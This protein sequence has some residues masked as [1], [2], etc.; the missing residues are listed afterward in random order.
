MKALSY[1]FLLSVLPGLSAAG[2]IEDNMKTFADTE[3]RSK[4]FDPMIIAAIKGA[5]LENAAITPEEI[6]ALDSQWKQD[7]G[8]KS[9]LISG[10]TDS[11][12]ST[13]LRD[14]VAA[15]EGKITEVI[16]MDAKGLN[17]A[18]SDVTSDYWQGDEDKHQQTFGLGPDAIHVS[19][20]EFDESTQT[21]QAQVSFTITDPATGLGIGAATIGLNA[22]SF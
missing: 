3:V 16:L 15:S 13:V 19:E 11:A 22:A 1:A 14:Y 4:L 10:V 21:Y 5:N 8:T 12:A 7:V 6:L 2:S 18:V 17:V 20:I 9:A